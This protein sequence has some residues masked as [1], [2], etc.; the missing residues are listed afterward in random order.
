MA[1]L[2]KRI[3]RLQAKI[4]ALKVKKAKQLIAEA[5]ELMGRKPRAERRTRRTRR[6]RRVA[7]PA[8]GDKKE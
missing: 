5:R 1:D 4:D 6:A 8:N 7:K 3:D 2:G